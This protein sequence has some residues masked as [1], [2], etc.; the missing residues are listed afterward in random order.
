MHDE[1]LPYQDF[2]LKELLDPEYHFRPR[3]D[4]REEGVVLFGGS[5][6][7][8]PSVPRNVYRFQSSIDGLMFP[9]AFRFELHDP[10]LDRT[11][12]HSYAISSV[13]ESK[14]SSGI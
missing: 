1:E 13:E 7:T 4:L 11:L 3:P 12:A 9:T 6:G 5:R 2:T 14:S 10:I 8:L